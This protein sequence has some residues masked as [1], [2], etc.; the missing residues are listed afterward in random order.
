MPT[1]LIM[2]GAAAEKCVRL[3]AAGGRLVLGRGRGSDV[4]L[5]DHGPVVSRRHAEI[6]AGASGFTIVDLGSRNG[7]WRR[8]ARIATAALDSVEP[9]VIGP[10]HLLLDEDDIEATSAVNPVAASVDIAEDGSSLPVPAGSS[11]AVL[12]AAGIVLG[13]VAG[14]FV[15]WLLLS[16]WAR[17]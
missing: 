12:I 8:G 2:K 10:Y 5:P 13:L 14:G 6:S 7:V 1:L 4:V 15:M 16:A 9:I 17:S 11:A 3:P